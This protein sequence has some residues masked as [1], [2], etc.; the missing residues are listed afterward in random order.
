[1]KLMARGG[2]SPAAGGTVEQTI[3]AISAI[4]E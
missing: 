1:M 3:R 4:H 2:E